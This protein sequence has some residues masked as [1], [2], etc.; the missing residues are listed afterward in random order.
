MKFAH[1]IELLVEY[2]CELTAV[3]KKGKLLNFT[4]GYSVSQV[5]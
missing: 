3:K 2:N 1:N 5:I 4:L